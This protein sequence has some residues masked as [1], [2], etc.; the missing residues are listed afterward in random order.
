M[1]TSQNDSATCQFDRGLKTELQKNPRWPPAV[2][3][4]FFFFIFYLNDVFIKKNDNK[5]DPKNLI[6]QDF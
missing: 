6:K 1:Q 4:I 2:G 5:Y 3:G